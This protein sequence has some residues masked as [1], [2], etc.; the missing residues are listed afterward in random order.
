MTN[1]EMIKKILAEMYAEGM[2]NIHFSLDPQLYDWKTTE[3]GE[4]DVS[5]NVDLD[6]ENLLLEMLMMLKGIR[7]Y[8]ALPKDEQMKEDLKIIYENVRYFSF[9]VNKKDVY[10]NILIGKWCNGSTRPSKSFSL[11]SILSFPAIKH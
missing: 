11:S 8:Q 9:N 10:I 1:R 6:V 3:D 4:L 2:K 5:L 7:K